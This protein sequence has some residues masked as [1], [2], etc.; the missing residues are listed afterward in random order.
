SP[1]DSHLLLFPYTT[2]FRSFSPAINVLEYRTLNRVWYIFDPRRYARDHRKLL[3]VDHKIAFLGG[4]NIGK[5]Y[6]TQWR[7]TH[8]RIHGPESGRAHV[9]TTGT[10]E[11]RI[12]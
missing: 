2:P 10:R 5:L 8:L 9:R 11:T 3:V 4:F 7:D 6:A 12:P 1:L